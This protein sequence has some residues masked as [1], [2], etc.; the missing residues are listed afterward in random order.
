MA[1]KTESVQSNYVAHG[2]D[3]QAAQLGLRKATKEDMPVYHGWALENPNQFG[4]STTENYIKNYLIQMVNT[5][6]N[7]PVVPKNAPRM[8]TPQDVEQVAETT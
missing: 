2:S 5:L 7:T 8:W 4:P 1:K 3:E 6:E